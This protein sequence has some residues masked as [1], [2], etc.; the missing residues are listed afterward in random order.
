MPITQTEPAPLR[1]AAISPGLVDTLA[2]DSLS[3]D[4]K[5]AMFDSTAK[6]LP[7]G[8]TGR[9]LDIDGGARAAL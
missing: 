4:T 8:R 9:L 5:S 2:Y 7:V 3:D 6:S 1:M